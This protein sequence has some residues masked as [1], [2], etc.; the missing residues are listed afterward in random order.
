[1]T[2]SRFK[3]VK[4]KGHRKDIRAATKKVGTSERELALRYESLWKD[5]AS[6]DEFTGFLTDAAD[7]LGLSSAT[8]G[9]AKRMVNALKVVREKSVWSRFGWQGGICTI[10]SIP[11]A[12][13][14]REVVKEVLR[15]LGGNGTGK[16]SKEGLKII[17]RDLAPSKEIRDS[18]AFENEQAAKIR[19]LE[20]EKVC[21]VRN[22]KGIQ[23]RFPSA[24][25]NQV[26]DDEC[27][28]ILA[29][30]VRRRRRRA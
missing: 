22:L 28:E 13:E 16:L 10:V 18:V 14:R 19:Q 30:T 27:R 15:K 2:V 3:S 7:G 21:L 17:I 4:F 1:M 5:C 12:V 8:A 11:N 20:L 6:S 29:S 9:V 24:A 26:I 25:V 23:R